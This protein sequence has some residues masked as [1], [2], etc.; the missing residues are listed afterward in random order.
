MSRHIADRRTPTS[1]DKTRAFLEIARKEA[2][3]P[4]VIALTRQPRS[5][6]KGDKTAQFVRIDRGRTA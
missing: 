6:R 1:G 2:P 4:A 5:P 3:H